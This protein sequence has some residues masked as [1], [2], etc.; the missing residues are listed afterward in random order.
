VPAD[1]ADHIQYVAHELRLTLDVVVRGGHDPEA[2]G[3][4]PAMVWAAHRMAA[5]VPRSSGW[6]R[7]WAALAREL[8]GQVRGVPRVADHE[9]PRD[10][11]PE[12]GAIERPP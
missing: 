4:R 1:E 8:P 11:N 5:A 9:G 7:H 3:S 6:I 10:R 12:P 2:W